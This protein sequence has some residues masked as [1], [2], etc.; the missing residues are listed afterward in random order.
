M[1]G[2]IVGITITRPIA[3]RSVVGIS[4]DVSTTFQSRGLNL[5]HTHH[6]CASTLLNGELPTAQSHSK[7]AAGRR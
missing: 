2:V 6:T 3:D 4:L 7:D 1:A 5:R